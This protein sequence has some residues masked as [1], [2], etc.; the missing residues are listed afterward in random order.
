MTNAKHLA[1]LIQQLHGQG[2][3]GIGRAGCVF[4]CY[5]ARPTRYLNTCT[6]R[7]VKRKKVFLCQAGGWW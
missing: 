7:K 1:D 2:R 3:P 4:A 5:A 6:I